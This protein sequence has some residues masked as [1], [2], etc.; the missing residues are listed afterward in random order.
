[1][2]VADAGCEDGMRDLCRTLIDEF[3]NDPLYVS[4]GSI[5]S[6]IPEEA[7]FG[8]V[9]LYFRADMAQ[10]L[11]SVQSTNIEVYSA[12]AVKIQSMERMRSRRWHYLLQQKSATRISSKARG[13]QIRCGENIRCQ[14]K[15]DQTRPARR[16]C[17][18]I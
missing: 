9:R 10:A 1:M 12:V 5:S 4:S 14:T 17:L 13:H 3:K 7:K 8:R 2:R 18:Y 15:R 6:S 11:D 16:M